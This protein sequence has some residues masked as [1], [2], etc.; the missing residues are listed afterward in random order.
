MID[1]T[2]IIHFISLTYW[3]PSRV[4]RVNCTSSIW[5]HM[6]ILKE[7]SLLISE[8]MLLVSSPH[9]GTNSEFSF[10]RGNG[11][12]S[13]NSKG[14]V[15]LWEDLGSCRFFA[16]NHWRNCGHWTQVTGWGCRGSERLV[17]SSKV[18]QEKRYKSETWIQV[19]FI[20]RCSFFHSALGSWL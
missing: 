3:L 17:S 5:A 1:L 14:D 2:N 10:R 19:C 16:Q 13:Q 4:E 15:Y 7:F 18:S 20:V 11:V 6:I 8:G 9:S 12:S